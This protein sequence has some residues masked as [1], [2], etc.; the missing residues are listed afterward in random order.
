[1]PPIDVSRVLTNSPKAH[2]R[3]RQH[4]LDQF[5]IKDKLISQHI[6]ICVSLILIDI[7]VKMHYEAVNTGSSEG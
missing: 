1:M 5:E 2:I 6:F 3:G 7:V 4:C